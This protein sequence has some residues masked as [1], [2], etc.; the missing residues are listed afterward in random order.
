M[1]TLRTFLLA[2][3]AGLA[4]SIGGV[5]FLSCESKFVGASLFAVGLL[6]VCTFGLNLYTGKVCYVL[7]NKPGYV[8][9]VLLIWLGNLVGTT[10]TGL[11]IRATRLTGVVEKAYDL[12]QVKLNDSLISI[13]ILAIF[14]NMMI[15]LAVENYKNNPHEIGKYMAIYFGVAVFIMAGFEHCVANMFYFAV[16][17]CW[18][19]KTLL[20]LVVMTL[21]NAVGGLVIPVLRKIG[22]PKNS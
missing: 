15:Y 10:A 1:K 9:D 8:L 18:S 21:G 22:L 20:Y 14:C 6:M 2:V 12:C 5:V 16:A 13:F 7:D 3:L 17:G 11:M 19:G 4:I